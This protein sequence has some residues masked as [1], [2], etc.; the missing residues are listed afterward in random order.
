MGEKRATIATALVLSA[1]MLLYSGTYTVSVGRLVVVKNLGAIGT[2]RTEPGLYFKWPWPFQSAVELDGRSHVLTLPGNEVLTQDKFNLI[3]SVSVG[4]RVR[5]DEASVKQF[6][7]SLRGSV[8]SAQEKI[9][10]RAKSVRKRVLN[11]IKLAEIISTDK[12]Q[13]EN[14]NNFEKAM[15]ETLQKGLDEAGYGIHIDFLYVESLK[16]PKDVTEKVFERMIKERER[17]SARYL[18]E[19]Q[20]KAKIIR[21]NAETEK[22]KKLADAEA[23]AIVI[24]GQADA[25]IADSYKVFQKNADLAIWLRQIETLRRVLK[26]RST[27]VLPNDKAL[28]SLLP[29]P[30]SEKAL[31]SGG[32]K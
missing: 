1:A 16:F 23:K 20:N 11:K 25:A 10:S 21:D 17:V 15:K 19:G 8:D 13:S 31:S 4:W 24:R 27:I 7:E 30:P 28:E 26:R 29:N 2:I 3:A 12:Q 18:A 32:K 5:S 14:F 22:D 9:A 6:L